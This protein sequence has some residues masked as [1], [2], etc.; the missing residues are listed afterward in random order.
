MNELGHTLRE[1]REALGFSLAEAEDRTRIRQKFIAAMETEDWNALPGD[2]PTRG[3]LRKYATFLELNP[4]EIIGLYARRPDASA[5]QTDEEQTPPERPLDYRPIELALAEPPPRNIP[6]RLI[7]LLLLLVVVVSAGWWIYASQ[8]AWIN[9]LLALPQNLPQA[10]DLIALETTPTATIVEQLNRVTAT[11]TDTAEPAAESTAASTAVAEA[12]VPAAATADAT[13][14]AT[15]A[16]QDT[17][18]PVITDVMRLHLNLLARSWV[19]LVIDGKIASETVMEQGGEGDW[20]ARESIVLRTG[21]AAGVQLTLN[22]EDLPPLGGPGEVIE[23]RWDLVD[24]EIIATTP[25]APPS[26][27]ATDTAESAPTDTPTP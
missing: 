10:G 4:E 19:R 25:T 20:E 2:V 15:V 27:V 3:F 9:N 6:W 5:P 17:P 16:P 8:P 18:P 24:G 21:N 23:R 13:V 22:G 26:P 14:D 11:P 7:L 1:A 12:T